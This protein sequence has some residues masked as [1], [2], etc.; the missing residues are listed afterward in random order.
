MARIE[1]MKG[2]AYPTPTGKSSVVGDLPWHF[3][4][5]H[6]SVVYRTDPAAIRSFLPE[7]LEP[8][9]SPD[10][11]IVDF[12]K[13][14]SLWDNQRDM[15]Y[16]NPERTWYQE[17]VLWVGSSYKGNQGKTCIQSWVNKDFSLARGMFMG[18]NK[19]FGNT[20]K[21]ECIA[22][23]P[24]MSEIGVGAKL[25]G[26]TCS[27]GERLMEGTLEVKEKINYTD[28]PDPMNKPLY[29]IRYFPSIVKGAAPS[30]CELI[31]LHM[32]NAS[33]GDVWSGQGTIDFY[34]ADFEEYTLL[35][36]EEVLGAYYYTNGCTIT[37]G[38]V[39]YSWV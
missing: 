1:D 32:E 25:K 29:N 30:V 16:V 37:G 39:L 33:N 14:Y 8:G 4:T 19:K 2:F 36:P 24:Q 35:E 17:T 18:F 22:E 28:L 6:L 9:E 26:W 34:P 3:G 15:S 7:P 31:T 11:V 38:K 10:I 5:E 21:T 27:H 20:Y 12:G 23:N 13:W